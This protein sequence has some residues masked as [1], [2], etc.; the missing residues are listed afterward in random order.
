MQLGGGPS[1]NCTALVPRSTSNFQYCVHTCNHRAHGGLG[2]T[3][4]MCHLSRRMCACPQPEESCVPLVRWCVSAAWRNA[5]VQRDCALSHASGRRRPC[6]ASQV[7]RTVR[8]RTAFISATM[9]AMLRKDK[10]R[11]AYWHRDR[12]NTIGERCGDHKHMY[13]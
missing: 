8:C 5:C 4:Y 11:R 9:C 7:C 1:E 6:G 10:D 12:F 13:A 2:P 3:P